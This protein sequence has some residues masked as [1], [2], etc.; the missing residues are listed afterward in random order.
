MGIINFGNQILTY[1]YQ[2]PARSQDF[3]RL[4]FRL[5]APGLYWFEGQGTVDLISKT[6]ANEA[7][8]QPMVCFLTDESTNTG[9]RLETQEPIVITVSNATPYIVW[10]FTWNNVDKW[11]ADIL[12]LA[13]S[14][15]QSTDVILGRAVYDGGTLLETFDYTRQ[16][17]VSPGSGGGGTGTGSA[18]IQTGSSDFLV[19]PTEPVSNRVFVSSGTFVT[20]G[21]NNFSG[22]STGV[23]S[24][25]TAGNERYD[26]VFLDEN[27]QV[28]VE[29]GTQA[30]VGTAIIPAFRGRLVVGQIYRQGPSS[31]IIGNN[32]TQ[33]AYVRD[34]LEIERE[35][36]TI[37]NDSNYIDF[38]NNVPEPLVELDFR[39]SYGSD[40]LLLNGQTRSTLF[41]SSNDE[42]DIAQIT[43]QEY[44]PQNTSNTIID[45]YRGD[46]ENITTYTV[47]GAV[48]FDNVGKKV[49]FN[50]K[51]NHL[52]VSATDG[53]KAVT[54]WTYNAGLWSRIQTITTPSNDVGFAVGSERIIYIDSTTNAFYFRQWNGTSY[55]S[56][57]TV[58]LSGAPEEPNLYITRDD[59]WVFLVV[60]SGS[61]AYKWNG[62]TYVATNDLNGV[63]SNGKIQFGG[64][65]PDSR[66]F[67]CRDGFSAT[68][69]V[70]ILERNFSTET[71]SQV[72][73]LLGNGTNYSG[74]DIRNA[75]FG[76]NNELFLS[77]NSIGVHIF[78]FNGTNW[79]TAPVQTITSGNILFG[80]IEGIASR[81]NILLIG[82]YN[83]G[84]TGRVR[85][86][87]WNGTS[88]VHERDITV[89]NGTNVVNDTTVSSALDFGES[90][91]ISPEFFLA[92]G[93]PDYRIDGDTAV[94]VFTTEDLKYSLAS[95]DIFKFPIEY[96]T[97]GILK[98][99]SLTVSNSFSD[100]AQQ[101]G[102]FIL[103]FSGVRI[104]LS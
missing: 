7:T 81:G 34:K 101:R 90:V 84:T 1:D 76:E 83:N 59:E 98:K 29:E 60:G 2:Q 45:G 70:R 21:L 30:P 73:N 77:L 44:L 56:P 93:S 32:I 42:L 26:L 41:I 75:E 102:F 94:G 23:I 51:Y 65:S 31:V 72:Q 20:T 87:L 43:S 35:R 5:H 85:L 62:T 17:L 67:A 89:S 16:N 19:L 28:Q 71:W 10:R 46:W 25:V 68:A 58:S 22:A 69:S 6:D 74:D 27:A 104:P 64:F 39:K 79:G 96:S 80:A 100:I 15:I 57:S 95:A 55:G 52:L 47:P 78:N 13:F 88:W 53:P 4:N 91:D 36:K 48:Q 3:N 49:K 9:V 11:Y 99:S 50:Q 14:D 92:I 66:F 33:V 61:Q 63:F 86:Y 18:V 38:D 97:S 8:L 54:V 37:G 12:V 24:S 82:D 40:E 103:N